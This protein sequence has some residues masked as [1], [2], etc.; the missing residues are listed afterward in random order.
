M[1]SAET[2]NLDSYLM[3][4]IFIISTIFKKLSGTIQI[5]DSLELVKGTAL[6][7][8]WNALPM[9]LHACDLQ[10]TKSTELEVLVSL[11]HLVFWDKAQENARHAET[12]PGRLHVERE[13]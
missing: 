10:E 8:F 6:H 1:I 7:L 12:L 9:S 2:R 3:G 13:Q 4:S 11:P 5:V